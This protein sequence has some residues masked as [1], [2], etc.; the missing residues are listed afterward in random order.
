[1]GSHGR[2]VRVLQDF[3]TRAGFRAYVDGHFGPG[4][5]RVVRRW[6]RATALAVD[7]RV[8]PGDAQVLRDKVSEA[9]TADSGPGGAAYVQV[10]KGTVNPDGTAVAPASAPD[11]VKQIIAAGNEIAS[12]PY[13][14]GGGH[15]NYDDSGYDCSGSVSYALHFAGLLGEAL[16]STGFESYGDAGHG[17]WVSVYGSSGHAYLV[18]AG[19]RFDTSGAKARGTRWTT[20]QRSSSGYVARHP[21]GL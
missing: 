12:K 18:V 21:A 16:D 9:E 10:E 2:D 20:E 14:Y 4:T 7:G 17:T 13:K 11:V 15:G 3:L 6:E 8:T 19:L 1:M 5:R